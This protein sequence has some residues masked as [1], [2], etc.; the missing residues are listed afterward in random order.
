MR[1]I[2]S[3]SVCEAANEV[4]DFG[5]REAK[6]LSHLPQSR[7]LVPRECEEAQHIPAVWTERP[8]VPANQ[9]TE[10]DI[11]SC[12]LP[13]VA[14]QQR[15]GEGDGKSNA[16][17]CLIHEFGLEP[18]LPLDSQLLD[19]AE[20]LIALK[21]NDLELRS[22]RESFGNLIDASW[23]RH[24]HDREVG[25]HLGTQLPEPDQPISPQM[26]IVNHDPGWLHVTNGVFQL[27][28]VPASV[29]EPPVV[30]HQFLKQECFSDSGLPDENEIPLDGA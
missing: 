3:P 16:S 30:L 22:T 19:D 23:P 27:A 15:A 26:R 4:G 24:G 12:N 7:S 25:I 9:V 13:Y 29:E 18:H 10:K 20:G 1:L 21:F 5:L 17:V 2:Q 8:P 11:T 6:G 28:N 14:R